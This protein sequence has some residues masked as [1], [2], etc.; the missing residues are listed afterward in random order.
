MAATKA[1][2]LAQLSRKLTYNE[3]TDIASINGQGNVL[4]TANTTDDLTQG[5]TNLYYANSLVDSHLSGGTSITYTNGTIAVVQ[6]V[7]TSASPTFAGLTVGALS[8]PATD[9]T[10][11]QV[12]V[13][14]G[15]GSLSFEDI[16]TIQ[17][18]AVNQTASSIAKGTPVYQTG[19]SG[20]SIT[21]APADAS[22]SST[23][24][25]IGV[26]DATM[27]ANGGTANVIHM[28]YVKGFDTSSFSEG[29]TLFISA[30][31]GF[32]TTA[33]A[34]EANLIQNMARVIKSH[35]TNGSIVV[36][37]AGRSNAVANLNDG[38]IF[39]GNSSNQPTTASLDTTVAGL[40]YATQTYVTTQISNLV[41]SA[42]STLDTLNELAAALGDDAN[43]STTVTTSLADK[44][45]RTSDD[46]DDLSEGS[47]NLYYTD[48]RVL[49][50][51]DQT[52]I[53]SLNV[54]ADT[55]DN[56]HYDDII[57]E[58]TALAIAL[59]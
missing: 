46:T 51:V 33:P 17:T 41:D 9:G 3:S 55:V 39:I 32:T 6:D 43:F 24:P 49:T 53:N 54:N 19:V 36:M 5:S 38:N 2:E 57:S 7:A 50:A 35:A 27:S 20:N 37:G 8:Y 13:T 59:G 22:S 1:T 40:G 29:D 4:T 45:S 34:G 58:A 28:G 56:K 47:T 12:I 42:P 21:V 11:R 15:A 10:D 18:A 14:D 26:V 16:E 44:I 52:Y 30:S 23:M 31:G 25:A 48:A